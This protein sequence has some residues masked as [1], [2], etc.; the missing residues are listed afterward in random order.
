M[1]IK[2]AINIIILVVIIL[3][4][5]SLYQF[6]YF[7]PLQK[8]AELM[9]TLII[10]ILII[11]HFVYSTQKSI[12]QNYSFA[13]FLIFLSMFTSMMMAYIERDQRIIHTL[14]AQRALYY[15]FLYFL[16]H[17][18][19]F[20]T[21]DM[22]KII[23]FFA[24]LYVGLQFLQ[25]A[26]YPRVLFDATVR[27]ERGTIRIYIPG[28]H[29]IAIGF[30]LYLQKFL[31]SN[32]IKYS[33]LLIMIFSVYVMRGGRQSLAVITLVSVLFLIVD[34]RVRSR[35]I[36]ILLG[37]VG[38]FSIFIIFQSVFMELFIRSRRDISMGEEL[39]RILTARYFLTDFFKS[40]LAY[41]TGNGM[42]YNHSDYGKQIS[43]IRT[44]YHYSL[45]DIGLIGNY[46]IYGIFFVIGV[47]V[48]CIKT[49]LIKI[50]PK[51]T[52]VKYYFIAVIISLITSG[53]FA[54]SDFICLVVVL[55]YLT[56]I[57]NESYLNNLKF[58]SGNKDLYQE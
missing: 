9:G 4:S 5:T 44:V 13:L 15:Y 40:S 49:L 38:A 17:Q 54:S 50:E 14:F 45:G 51:Y 42:Y 24:I 32:K 55:L 58:N 7:G 8:G 25:T 57:S 28:S 29:Y 48:I 46:A 19:K 35:L 53:G 1:T 22:E 26:L 12:R 31:R 27:A 52:Y 23:I 6:S 56:D 11:F 41:I 36:M 3:C 43:H 16:L 10:F 21:K 2:R 20:D 18:M 34:I 33:F 47:I 30:Y 39:S 37:M